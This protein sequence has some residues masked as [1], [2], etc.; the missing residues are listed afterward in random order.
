MTHS[1]LDI[2]SQESLFLRDSMILK[3]FGPYNPR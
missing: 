2:D 1:L 3:H